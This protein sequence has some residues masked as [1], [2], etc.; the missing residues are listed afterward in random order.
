MLDMNKH[1]LT[2]N[3]LNNISNKILSNNNNTNHTTS[4]K[5]VNI[6]NNQSL[7]VIPVNN[8]QINEVLKYLQDKGVIENPIQD[9]KVQEI[10]NGAPENLP[11]KI[12]THNDLSKLN[13][14]ELVIDKN[15]IITPLAK[16]TAKTLGIKIIKY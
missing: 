16:D 8:D 13:I 14:K 10:G 12:I 15:T 5:P 11:K 7:I 6:S 9:N 2:K 3:I 4:I 1:N